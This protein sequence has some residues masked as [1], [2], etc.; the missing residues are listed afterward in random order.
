[1]K[2]D[3]LDGLL[4]D[5]LKAE[6]AVSAEQLTELEERV[7]MKLGDRHP[8]LRWFQWLG[9]L[10]APTRGTRLGQ[11]AVIGAT[12]AVF[13][14]VGLML[15]DRFLP[16]SE[17][18]RL[19][20]QPVLSADGTQEVLFVMPALNAKNVAVVGNFNAWEGTALSD[21]DGDG[22]WTASISLAPGRYEYAFIIDGRWWG[23]DPLADEYIQSF[24]EYSSVRY[25]GRGGD[26][27]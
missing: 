23:Q 21:S 17:A 18:P 24:G 10:L 14:F 3:E 7:I 4:R 8:R 9:Q 16:G 25:I 26:D 13:L 19:S 12:A 27:A 5:T 20:L 15:S 6:V 11:V 2:H 1:M 22:I